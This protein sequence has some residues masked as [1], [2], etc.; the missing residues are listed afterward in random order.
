MHITKVTLKTL[1][2]RFIKSDHG[3]LILTCRGGWWFICRQP[4]RPPTW[5]G[6][7]SGATFS[8][9][10]SVTSSSHKSI[11]LKLFYYCTCNY[12][13]FETEVNKRRITLNYD[14]FILVRSRLIIKWCNSLW[15]IRAMGRKRKIVIIHFWTHV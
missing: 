4:S 2:K 1:P 10:A 6:C 3:N 11:S 9:S 13:P 5:N 15:R 14:L 7:P 8:T 12:I